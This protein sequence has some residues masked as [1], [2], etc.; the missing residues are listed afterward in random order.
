MNKKAQGLV[1]ILV[2]E[3][4]PVNLVTVGMYFA[5]WDGHG[6]KTLVIQHGLEFEQY[7]PFEQTVQQLT[8]A[9]AP[10]IRT[11][12]RRTTVVGNDVFIQT[13]YRHPPSAVGLGND[14][15]RDIQI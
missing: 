10:A 15:E 4:R 13:G 9:L 5:Q 3:C 14:W 11:R 1:G 12:W 7:Q 2:S 6:N 8:D